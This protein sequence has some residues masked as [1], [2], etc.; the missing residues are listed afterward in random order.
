MKRI[1]LLSFLLIFLSS[2]SIYNLSNFIIP[3]DLEFLICIEKLDSPRKIIDYIIDNFEYKYHALKS[4]D[5][6]TLWKTKKGDCD[7]FSAF[8]VFVANFHGYETY[9][10]KVMMKLFYGHVFAIYKEGNKYSFSS[11]FDYYE[12]E[13]NSFREIVEYFFNE[14][15]VEWTKYIVYDYWN[16]KVEIG[17]N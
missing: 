17:Y 16:N 8:A 4:I 6:Y 9:Q 7:N 5:P 11:N 12:P 1:I 13:Y 15:D 2:C 3:D 10:I 14:E